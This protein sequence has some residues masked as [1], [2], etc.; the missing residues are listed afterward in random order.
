MC[1]KDGGR[2]EGGGRGNP[3]L[4]R[5]LARQQNERLHYFPHKKNVTDLGK[6]IHE[7]DSEHTA[8]RKW[9]GNWVETLVHFRGAILR[10]SR[11]WYRCFWDNDQV[12]I[13]PMLKNTTM[14]CSN[15]PIVS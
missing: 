13:L 15:R 3:Y 6:P 5:H 9:A 1:E 4:Y 10:I 11:E 7:C 8:G 12:R 14:P 2:R